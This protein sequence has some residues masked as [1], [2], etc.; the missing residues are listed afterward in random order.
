MH[1]L[2]VRDNRGPYHLIRFILYSR[3]YCHLCDDMLDALQAL[4]AAA[5]LAVELVDVDADP[6]LLAAYDELVPVLLGI[7]THGVP[8]QLCHYFLDPGAVQAFI[9]AQDPAGRGSFRVGME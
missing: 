1:I 8:R 3:T 5:G 4:P 9:A 2:F 7:D 6:A